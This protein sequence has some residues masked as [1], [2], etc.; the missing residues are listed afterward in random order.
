M[1]GYIACDYALRYPE[2]ITRLVLVSAFGFVRWSDE[3]STLV[4]TRKLA[5]YIR[6]LVT[7]AQQIGPMAL[8]RYLGPFGVR[9]G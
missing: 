5:W 7:I 1:G 3:T 9:L 2:R 6:P 4:P 8:V